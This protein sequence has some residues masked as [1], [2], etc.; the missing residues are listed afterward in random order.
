MGDKSR[1]Q[2]EP[3]HRWRLRG[4]RRDEPRRSSTRAPG[5]RSSKLPEASPSRSTAPSPRRAR[6]LRAG[7]A[8][9]R[10]ER[11]PLLLRIADRI[12]AEAE[13]FAALEA[14]N[15][16]KPINAAIGDE[17]PAWSTASAS[18]PARCGT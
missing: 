5:P 10:A 4:R 18:S 11:S 7:R 15:C 14:L 3:A 17:I 1:M 13:E 9:R 16:G 12:E 6:S 2:T 8:R